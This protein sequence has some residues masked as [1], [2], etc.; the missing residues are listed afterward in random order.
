MSEHGQEIADVD[1]ERAVLGCVITLSV[2][3]TARGAVEGTGPL[4]PEAFTGSRRH[5]WEAVLALVADGQAVD[6]LTLADRLKARGRLAECGGPSA[7]MAFDQGVPLTHNLPSYVAIL[8]DR[9]VRRQ[10]AAVATRLLQQAS[11]LGAD[12]HRTSLTAVQALSTTSGL[13]QEEAPDADIAELAAQWAAYMD[14]LEHGTPTGLD[15]GVL[16]RTGVEQLDAKGE[17]MPSNLCVLLGLASMG[18]TALAAEIIWNWLKA[19]IP[20]GIVGLE[21]GTKWL[22]RRHLA[23]HLGIPL[24]KV[25][26]TLLHEYQQERLGQWMGSTSEMY[27][28][29]LRIHRAGGLHA[30]DLL[31]VVTRWINAGVRWVWIDHGLRVDYGTPDQKR[32]DLAIGKTLEA[33]AT[34]G[35]RHGVV[36]AVNW[37]LNRMSDQETKPDMKMAKESGYLEAAARWMVATWEQKEKRPGMMLATALKVTEGP[38][39]WTV[40]LER[41]LECALVKSTGGYAVDFAAEAAEERQRAE[42]ERAARAPKR[43]GLFSG[44]T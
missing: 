30:S 22:T 12:A 28:R 34:L 41:D 29:H 18:K 19:G 9:R 40:A 11:D 31:A 15:D 38:R 37:H 20:G 44:G 14:R 2:A 6:H 33:L 35:E 4:P 42:D 5:V 17:G 8:R 36:I 1:A 43:R 39:D 27:R 23:R 26:R 32:Y 24:A 25:G 16:L 3:E 10:Q 21:D 13:G 7:L